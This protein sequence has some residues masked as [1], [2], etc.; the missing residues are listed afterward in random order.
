MS[1]FPLLVRLLEKKM[2]RWEPLGFKKKFCT[3]CVKTGSMF[4][5]EPLVNFSTV[6][7]GKL[8]TKILRADA[9]FCL[10]VPLYVVALLS[11]A[12]TVPVGAKAG[13]SSSAGPEVS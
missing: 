10:T 9:V 11:N 5:A 7:V 8:E 3:C 6:V 4:E 12:M 13:F 1:N 2:N